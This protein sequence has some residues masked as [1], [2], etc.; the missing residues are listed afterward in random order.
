[1]TEPLVN[2]RDSIRSWI[3]PWMSD[4]VP[5]GFVN[6]FKFLYGFAQ[7]C[8]LAIQFALEAAW[9]HFPSY[10]P[11]EA[12]AHIGRDRKIRRAP[13]E[14][15]EDYVI[16]LLEWLDAAKKRG[17]ATQTLRDLQVYAAP[18]TPTI[19]I[20]TASSLWWTLAPD[21]S[22]TKVNTVPASIWNWDDHPEKWDRFWIVLYASDWG[23]VRDGTWG[24]GETWGHDP[25]STWGSTARIEEVQSIRQI[26]RDNMAADQVCPRIIVSFDDAAFDP[27]EPLGVDP[28]P[29]G[30][31]G[32]WAKNVS[33][34]Y[35]PSRDP[36][37]IYWRGP[38][39]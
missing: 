39:A 7:T 1:M 14:S 32:K 26:V 4:R 18:L 31:W 37:A 29:D 16:R 10:A 34:D 12:L 27:T 25:A 21:G 13:N 23:W 9:S 5:Q 6:G 15:R 17:S 22:I 19:R 33:G 36:R 20:V 3:P 35:V 2:M 11:A 28:L 8:D 24:D 38:S 30:T